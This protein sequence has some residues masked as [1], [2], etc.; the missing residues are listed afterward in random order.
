MMFKNFSE[1]NTQPELMDDFSVGIQNL[2]GV[3]KDINSVNRVLGGNHITVNA[4]A[5]LMQENPQIKYTI[6]DMGC[7]DGCMLR[8]LAQYCKNEGITT[9]LI[10][11]DLN[12]KAL[13]LAEEASKEYPKI[14]Y[15]CKDIIELE[16]NTLSCDIL[17]NTLTMH[18]FTNNQ[19]EAFLQKFI[20]LSKIGVII[21][22][23]HRSPFAYYLFKLFSLIFIK[24]KIAKNDGLI[25]I[26]KGFVKSDL[27]TYA[28]KLPSVTHQI[29][30][31]WAFRYVWVMQPIRLRQVY[32]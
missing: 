8:E 15:L 23:L 22:D 6:V 27:L 11:I 4:V 24:T 18:H 1:R 31:K 30:W 17:I 29:E 19:I 12:E 5:K 3:F 9:R 26:T 28:K 16:A 10:G 2:R 14:E 32:D 21:N 13:Q 7:G 20:E 25:S